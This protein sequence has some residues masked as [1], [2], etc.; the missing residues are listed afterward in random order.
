[1]LRSCENVHRTLSSFQEIECARHNCCSHETLTDMAMVALT[2]TNKQT[3]KQTNKQSIK[4]TNKQTN[5]HTHTHVY[6]Y[7]YIFL[8]I[9]LS[10]SP[11]LS[12]EVIIRNAGLILKDD[13]TRM[14]PR[15][16]RSGLRLGNSEAPHVAGQIHG[17]F[18][19][20]EFQ[21]QF[22]KV[23]AAGHWW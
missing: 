22:E 9:S 16:C 23:G 14:L 10:L 5:K 3:S 20:Q 2:H 7:I 6:V 19:R 18:S 4:Q 1:M 13:A 11:S 17:S 12:L 15:T 21:A 8:Y